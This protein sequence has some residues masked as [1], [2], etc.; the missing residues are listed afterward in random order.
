MTDEKPVWSGTPSQLLNFPVFAVCGLLFWL[1]VPLFVILW[2]WI[3]LK[4]T[5]YELTTERFRLRYGVFNRRMDELELYRV[6]DYKLEQPFLLRLFGLGNIQLQTSDLSNP[7][8]TIRAI[9]DAEA[10][11]EQIRT[12]VEACR[13]KKGVREYDVV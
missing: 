2:S 8:V 6:R 13:V 5:R 1:V 11:R 10:V 4:M 3:V 9:R 12:Y 7:V